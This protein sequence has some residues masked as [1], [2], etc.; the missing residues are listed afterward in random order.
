ML[1]LESLRFA[2]DTCI[3]GH[4]SSNCAHRDRDL[5][6]LRKKGRPRHAVCAEC[7]SSKK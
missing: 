6:E 3:R 4:R 2:C 5:L 7:R 1:V